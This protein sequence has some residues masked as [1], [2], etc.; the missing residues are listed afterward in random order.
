MIT[1]R[2][3]WSNNNIPQNNSPSMTEFKCG[4]PYFSFKDN[5]IHVTP[6]AVLPQQILPY[7]DEMVYPHYPKNVLPQ[8]TSGRLSFIFFI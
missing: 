7:S 2:F 3:L 8:V 1:E 4:V 6:I 5:A